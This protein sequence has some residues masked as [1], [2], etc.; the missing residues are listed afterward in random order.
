M[1]FLSDTLFWVFLTTGFTVGFGHCI[2]M[3]G[4]IVVSMSLNL[5]AKNKTIPQLLYHA[6]RITTYAL[7]GGLM[8][9]TGSFTM[10]TAQIAL[11]Q[12]SVLIFA[13]ILI[14]FMGLLMSPWL[15][16]ISCFQNNSTLGTY[17]SKMFQSLVRLKSTPAYFPLGLL[18]G[19]LP[20]GPVYTV[21]IASARAG[22]DAADLFSGFISGMGLTLAFGVGT[23][24]SLFIIGKLAGVI[25][26]N[27]RQLI[28]KFG[29]I[30]MMGVG[31]YFIIKGIQH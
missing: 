5:D 27:Q 16:N 22:M 12:K 23:I 4:P 2:G 3:C 24:P 14:I 19:L 1:H 28:Y 20:C 6:G 29:S 15:L 31:I 30:I 18:L 17:F 9:I 10:V 8:G 7:L 11:I 13:G 25:K 26:V 21:L